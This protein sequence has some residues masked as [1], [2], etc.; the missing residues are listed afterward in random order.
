MTINSNIDIFG[1]GIVIL[2]WTHV[3]F[4]IK[5]RRV[6]IWCFHLTKIVDIIYYL[7]TSWIINEFEKCIWILLFACLLCWPWFLVV[8]FKTE[9][10]N[11]LPQETTH[12]SIR[13][14]CPY[15]PLEL[16]KALKCEE[17][18]KGFFQRRLDIFCM[19]ISLRQISTKK[20]HFLFII[21]LAFWKTLFWKMQTVF[22]F[23]KICS[24]LYY[25]SN[26]ILWRRTWK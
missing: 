14:V 15:G 8:H 24:Q 23:S 10:A 2:I 9:I 22:P 25:S 19:I 5:T 16:Y 3:C 20:N 12:F 6:F 1:F 13:S 18:K 11:I 17:F 26:H 4:D 7:V 21:K